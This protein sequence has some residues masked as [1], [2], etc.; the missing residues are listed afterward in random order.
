LTAAEHSFIMLNMSSVSATS[1]SGSGDQRAATG[2]PGAD[3]TA[4]AR[5]RDAAIVRFA[6]DG[7]A[8]TSVRAIAADA[9]VSPALVMHHYGSKDAL[10][11]ACDQHV[12]ALV[13]EQKTAAMA[14]GAQLDPLGA[15]RQAGEGPPVLRYLARTLVDGSP[16]VAELVDE[17]VADADAYMA[18]GVESG[19]L[20]PADDPRG[21]ATVLTL[22]SLGALVLHEHAQRL[23]G[24]DLAGDLASDPAAALAYLR[25]ATEILGRGVITDTSYEQL[26]AGLPPAEEARP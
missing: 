8:G 23:L 11:V 25:P 13:R 24:V 9:G 12:A 7:V 15:L 17:L 16:H 6:D 14:A 22:W 19:L 4:R 21:R 26:R 18:A 2:A 10:R 3:L 20:R 5:I 1:T